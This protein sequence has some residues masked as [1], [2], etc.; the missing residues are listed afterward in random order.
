MLFWAMF[1][2]TAVFGV[3]YYTSV[4]MRQLERRMT[5]VKDDLHASREKLQIA[6]QSQSTASA[7]EEATVERG[8]RMREMIADIQ[9][10]L[11][12]RTQVQEE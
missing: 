8:V 5:K 10:R 9:E 11:A 4:Q 7:E 1:A 12:A 2:A 6:Q 3:K